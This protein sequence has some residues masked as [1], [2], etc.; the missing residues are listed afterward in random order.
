MAQELADLAQFARNVPQDISPA[1]RAVLERV[2]PFRRWRFAGHSCVSIDPTTYRMIRYEG[3]EAALN[4]NSAQIA[5]LW[6]FLV[7]KEP[8][9]F[10][11]A[12][13]CRASLAWSFADPPRRDIVTVWPQV[14]GNSFGLHQEG[15]KPLR[16]VARSA[17]RLSEQRWAQELFWRPSMWLLLAIA[18]ALVCGLRGGRWRLLLVALA[19]PLGAIGS[20]VAAPAAQ[21]ARYTYAAT[22]MCQLLTVGYCARA[23]YRR[24]RLTQRCA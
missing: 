17:A 3:R 10:L 18:S 5:H 20:Y 13:L 19:V 9:E 8:G 21:D 22:L 1:N 2:A 24:R 4:A 16:H 14:S 12:R 6:R 15:P 7:K 23:I 11:H